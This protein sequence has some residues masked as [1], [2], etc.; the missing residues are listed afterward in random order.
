MRNLKAFMCSCFHVNVVHSHSI[1]MS[2][3]CDIQITSI[4]HIISISLIPL[5]TLRSLKTLRT[6]KTCRLLYP[7]EYLSLYHHKRPNM[8]YFLK[9]LTICLTGIPTPRD[10]IA[11]KNLS[12]GGNFNIILSFKISG[13]GNN[14][15]AF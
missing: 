5:K 1:F 9:F 12:S 7:I 4:K 2:H 14:H 13:M 10:A 3:R 15:Q 8:L 6:I 11:S